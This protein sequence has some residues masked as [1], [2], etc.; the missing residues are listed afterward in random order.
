MNCAYAFMQGINILA[1]FVSLF[2]LIDKYG[3]GSVLT[4][5]FWILLTLSLFNDFT[6]AIASTNTSSTNYLLGNKF[7]TGGI[8]VLLIG[9]FRVLLHIKSGKMP[10]N[11]TVYCALIIESIMVLLKA[12]AMTAMISVVSVCA[13][14]VLLGMRQVSFLLSGLAVSCSI[15]VLNVV[16]FSTGMLLDLPQVQ[17]F[18]QE[19]LGRSITMTGRTP[20]YEQLGIIIQMNPLFGWGYGN[21]VVEQIVGYGNAQNGI[22]Q[23]IVDYGVVGAAAFAAVI[24]SALPRVRGETSIIIVP[25]YGILYSSV[26][27][28]LVE[29]SFGLTF[30][31]QI[32]LVAAISAKL[33]LRQI[34]DSQL[35]FRYE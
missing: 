11:Q 32:A 31:F 1:L 35:S 4:A 3:A 12:D 7:T 2:R 16:F 23:V 17:Y 5:L 21:T 28:S 33:K 14:P 15:V 22:A 29:I 34:K 18:V 9:I 8:H 30:F 26:I 6:V 25:L 10:Y 13:L 27:S 24:I 20:I 19:V